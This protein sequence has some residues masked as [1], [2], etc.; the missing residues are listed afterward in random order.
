MSKKSLLDILED[1]S[2]LPPGEARKIY[3][4][5]KANLDALRDC[6][7]HRFE[8]REGTRPMDTKYRCAECGGVI[9]PGEYQWYKRGREDQRMLAQIGETEMMV[10]EEPE[11]SPRT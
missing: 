2:G 6:P 10:P 8:K 1:I 4:E 9:P 3:D 11:E 5:V 7:L